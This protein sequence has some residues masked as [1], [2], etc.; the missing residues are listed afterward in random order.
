MTAGNFEAKKWGYRQTQEGIVISF[1]CHPNDVSPE[2]ACAPLGT[3]YMVAFA[4]IGDDGQPEVITPK[5]AERKQEAKKEKRAWDQLTPTEQAGIR[6]KEEL[7]QE[8][9]SLT[10]GPARVAQP[11]T[12]EECTAWHIHIICEIGSR[13]ELNADP[14]AAR[15]WKIMDEAYQ[16]WFTE[17]KYGESRR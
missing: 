10:Y 1:L 2:I 15:R 8:W 4:K 5:A 9:A 12:A 14:V 7:F 6:C 17:R 11:L 13:R 16:A 3:H